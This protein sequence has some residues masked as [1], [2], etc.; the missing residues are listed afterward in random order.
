MPDWLKK[1]QACSGRKPKRQ[2]A[3]SGREPKE[4]QSDPRWPWVGPPNNTV[5]GP[6][7]SHICRAGR[8]PYFLLGGRA[9]DYQGWALDRS[10][11]VRVR[12]CGRSDVRVC[13]CG[14][15][16]PTI[17]LLCMCVHMVSARACALLLVFLFEHSFGAGVCGFARERLT[18]WVHLLL[19]LGLFVLVWLVGR[20]D[21]PSCLSAVGR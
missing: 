4:A 20:A 6:S 3:G 9:R 5:P 8:N 11:A 1:A 18:G 19:V 16:G 14:S 17:R 21:W 2:Q 12:V 15:L 7:F 13:R 10:N